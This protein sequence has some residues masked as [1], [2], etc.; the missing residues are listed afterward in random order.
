[1][2]PGLS[3]SVVL[4]VDR[5][6]LVVLRHRADDRLDDS[7]NDTVSGE[8]FN[9]A[10]VVTLEQGELRYYPVRGRLRAVRQERSRALPRR[11]RT[12]HGSST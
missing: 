4:V 5:V 6:H 9:G 12:L 1:M 3:R 8:E 11:S 2:L 10:H 7:F